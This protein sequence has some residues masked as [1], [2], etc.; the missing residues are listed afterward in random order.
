[1]QNISALTFLFSKNYFF[2]TNK[3]YIHV[4]VCEYRSILFHFLRKAKA[5][6]FQNVKTRRTV[7]IGD[8]VVIIMVEYN[9]KA[10]IIV[11]SK[12][13]FKTISRITDT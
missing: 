8:K 1:M 5:G 10:I 13:E 4:H 9:L 3:S 7:V 6:L 12:K 11:S 2:Y